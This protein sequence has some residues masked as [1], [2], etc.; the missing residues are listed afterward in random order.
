MTLSPHSIFIFFEGLCLGAFGYFLIIATI[1]V[2]GLL[3]TMHS[4]DMVESSS[5]Q[6][7]IDGSE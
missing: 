4:D 2:R 1:E 3:T 6:G 5:S 7:D